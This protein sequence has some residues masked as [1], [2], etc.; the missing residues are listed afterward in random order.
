[1]VWEATTDTSRLARS[2][3]DLL[4]WLLRA[5]VFPDGVVLSTG[6]GVVPQLDVSLIDGDAVEIDIEDV[7]TL[8]NT[9]R[10]G[11]DAFAWLAESP[12]RPA[13]ERILP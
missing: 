4:A 11:R 12:R 6:T 10:R 9:V 2:P 13:S 7:G 3:A 8:R 1:V 5:D